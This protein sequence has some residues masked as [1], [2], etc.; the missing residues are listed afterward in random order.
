[1]SA[2]A[3]PNIY[4]VSNESDVVSERVPYFIEFEPDANVLAGTTGQVI[5][6][7]AWRDFVCTQ[8]G[9]SGTKVGFPDPSVQPFKI[10]VEDIGASRMWQP[11]RWDI[12]SFI[13]EANNSARELPMPWVFKEK[14]SIRVEFENLGAI[15]C[16]PRLL[17]IGYLDI[18][19]GMIP[20]G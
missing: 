5:H 11:Q 16:T 18:P 15:D 3:M 17:L 12:G 6:T 9:F 20:R 13:G 8:V 2:N 19:P 4:P 1:M 14:T 7:I 10:M